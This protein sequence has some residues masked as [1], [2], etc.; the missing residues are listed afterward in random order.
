M[1]LRLRRGT[2]AERQSIT[3]LEGELIYATDTKELYVGDGSTQGGVLVSASLLDD[4][5]PMLSADLDLNGNDIVG[6]G[7]INISGTITATGTVNLGDGVEDNVVVGGQIGSSLIPGTTDAYNLG[8]SLARWSEVHAVSVSAESVTVNGEVSVG[9]I[10]TDGSIIKSDSTV[11]YDAVTGNIKVG[12]ILKS[13]DSVLYN[14]ETG[15]LSVSG[16]V[17]AAAFKGTLVGDDS[18]ILVDGVS[19]VL[20]NGVVTLSGDTF[21]GS[22]IAYDY[23]ITL[24]GSDPIVTVGTLQ[25]PQTLFIEG[26]NFPIVAR[27]LADATQGTNISIQA[28]RTAGGDLDAI[29]NGDFLGQVTFEAWNGSAFVKSSVLSSQI[30][31]NITSG[32]FDSNLEISV[33]NADGDYRQF[34]FK[35]DGS[36]NAGVGVSVLPIPDVALGSISVPEGTI[37]YGADKKSLVFY[38]G[39]GFATVSSLVAV[40]SGPT[41][42][43]KAGQIS[44][45]ADYIYFCYATDSWIRVAKDG[46]WA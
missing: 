39:S 27:G 6:T 17:S 23:D 32:A 3:P 28:S 22:T 7:N 45:D 12:S 38:D 25:N 40:P 13:D 37:G 20:S 29:Q 41:A 14:D 10:V 34:M 19:N 8:D 2:D 36:F 5:A 11:I 4:T 30:A 21:I 18:T 31:S 42:T 35:S 16:T 24:A 44:G 46:T 43:G 1:A 26:T 33:L 9:S 15:N